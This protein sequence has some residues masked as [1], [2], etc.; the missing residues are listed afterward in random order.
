MK[1][2]LIVFFTITLA[3][4]LVCFIGC[5]SD[6][7]NDDSSYITDGSFIYEIN[8]TKTGYL[9]KVDKEKDFTE[10]E[11]TIPSECNNLPVVGIMEWG[12]YEC[13]NL[14]VVVIPDSVTSIGTS[15]FSSCSNLVSVTIGSNVANIDENVFSGC[16]KLVEI[17]NKSN[18]NNS[19]FDSEECNPKIIHNEESKIVNENGFL[20]ITDN[21][22]NYLVSYIGNE[23]I[24]TLPNDFG[25]YE[26]SLNDYAFFNNYGLTDLTIPDKV[27]SIGCRAFYD[28]SLTN[29]VIGNGV[30]TISEESFLCCSNL[31]SVTLGRR[32]ENIG[33]NAFGQCVRLV[34]IIDKSNLEINVNDTSGITSY[35]KIVHNGE[36]KI[37]NENEYSFIS[38]YNM[39]KCLLNYTGNDS[40]ISLPDNCL[41]GSTVVKDVYHIN[42]Y[43]FYN[44]ESL[45]SITLPDNVMTIGKHAFERCNGLKSIT[46]PDSVTSIDK[47]A[48]FECDFLISVTVSDSVEC[49]GN[50]AFYGC[51]SLTDIVMG[52]KVEEIGV[53]AF[54][55]CPCLKNVYYKGT[56]EEWNKISVMLGNS[57]LED[58]AKYFYSEE[59]P[60]KSGNFWRYVNGIPTVWE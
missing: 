60:A 48:F 52:K 23:K 3:L 42:D 25:G 21:G 22:T 31:L 55:D 16:L 45:T 47:D 36:S 15:A 51:G 54:E 46:I 18:L 8:S 19:S 26:Y 9:I 58:A 12:F 1:K 44:C 13:A 7:S 11:L 17:V 14:S 37:V 20:F 41:A 10:T 49:I 40:V 34:E 33:N 38:I 4:S 56:Q 39:G 50:N 43:A 27:V 59:N 29:V 32:V 53:C 28:S 35:A 24:N 6:D 2:L 30:T 57:Y 5:G